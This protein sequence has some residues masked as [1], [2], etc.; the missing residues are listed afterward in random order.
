[1]IGDEAMFVVQTA[2]GA[3]EIGLSLSEAYAGDQLLSDVRVALAFGPV[4]VQDGDFYGSVVNLASRLVAVA[5]PGTVLI[6]DELRSALEA[7]GATEFT[8]RAI[9]SRT[10]KDIG[11]VQAW[12]LSRAGVEPGA[13]RRRTTRWERL[14][15]VVRDL[16]ELRDAGERVVH[17]SRRS[18]DGVSSR[19]RQSSGS[20]A[21]EPGGGDPVAGEL[22]SSLEGSDRSARQVDQPT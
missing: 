17:G 18:D 20:V 11:R 2:A 19:D 13:D 7:E 9:R 22:E 14:S 12:K 15:E 16:E 6:S 3:A 10:L 4:L 21:V 1:M 5:N 8:A